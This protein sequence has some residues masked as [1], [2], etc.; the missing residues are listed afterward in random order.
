MI[1]V[2][3][4]TGNIGS[5]LV[6]RL[7]ADGTP[8]RAVVRDP[9]RA[10]LPEG[11]EAVPGDLGAPDSLG[12][13]FAGARAA[14]VLP[15]YPGVVAAAAKSGVEHIVLLSGSSAGTGN[16]GN[17]VTRY[18]AA[19]EAE[20]TGP[21]LSWTILRPT[22]FMSNALRWLPQLRAGDTVRAQFP[23]VALASLDPADLAAVAA[24]ALLTDAHHGEILWPTGPQALLPTEQIEILGRALGRDLRYIPLSNEETRAELLKTTPPEYVDAFFD[25]YV[26]GAIDET[27]VRDTVEQVTGTPPRTFA[28]WAAAHADRFR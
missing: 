10:H 9:G 17:A 18:M 26:E 16:D 4:A 11:V 19:S 24:A 21:G 25:F 8:A 28:Q 6:T 15:G 5:E 13:A 27:T 22:A 3:G 7:A 12:P 14:F 1:V 20:V 23:T 2:T